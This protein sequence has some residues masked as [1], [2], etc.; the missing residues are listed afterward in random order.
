[1]QLQFYE[2]TGWESWG[3]AHK[4]DKDCKNDT[5][6]DQPQLATLEA[7]VAQYPETALGE[8]AK[9]LGLNF[10]KIRKPIANDFEP[11]KAEKRLGKRNAQSEV[12]KIKAKTQRLEG[13]TSV[14]TSLTAS[15]SNCQ[16]PIRIF[17]DHPKERTYI[18][19]LDTEK[20]KRNT[21]ISSHNLLSSSVSQQEDDEIESNGQT[22]SENSG[23]KTGRYMYQEAVEK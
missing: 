5:E 20:V 21:S 10:C 1:M 13:R 14:K 4:L 19:P 3:K 11:K 16:L 23:D 8:L 7:A 12:G 2:T 22:L 9:H 18:M 15:S 6:D 17:E